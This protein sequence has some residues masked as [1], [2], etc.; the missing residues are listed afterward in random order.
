V[1]KS[2]K[3]VLEEMVNVLGEARSEDEE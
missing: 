1:R 3:E 2:E